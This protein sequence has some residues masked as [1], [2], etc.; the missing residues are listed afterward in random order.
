MVPTKGESM[1]RLA[2][3]SLCLL[4]FALCVQPAAAQTGA[5]PGF[6]KLKTLVGEWAGK[7][8]EGKDG[9]A[10]YRLVSNGTALMEMLHPGGESEMVT[11]Y[12]ADGKRVA[13]THY[14]SANNQPRM[15]TVPLSASPQKLDF[16]YVGATNLASPTA[17]HMNRLVVTFQDNDHFTQDWTWKEPGKERVESIKFTR[18]K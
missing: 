8:A 2:W 9:Q 18:K 16:T 3:V 6:D 10:S 5:N 17:G 12:T 7:T 13:V 1:K 4:G 11:M 15:Q 14:C